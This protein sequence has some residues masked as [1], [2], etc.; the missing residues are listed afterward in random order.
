MSSAGLAAIE[1]RKGITGP[2]L[3]K[4]GGSL[5][6]GW[7]SG[8]ELAEDVWAL[9]SPFIPPSKRKQ[10]AIELIDLFEEHDC[11]TM[12]ECEDLIKAAG[13]ENRDPE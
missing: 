5:F 11:D 1:I 13:L 8:S 12:D 7:A 3:L 4:N 2:A 9:M 10:L 6:M